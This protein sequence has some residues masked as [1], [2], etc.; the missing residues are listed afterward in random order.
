M[1]TLA[2]IWVTTPLIIAVRVVVPG[3]GGVAG[4]V[5]GGRGGAM[6]DRFTMPRRIGFPVSAATTRPRMTP[7]P[8]GGGRRTVS[9]GGCPCAE[10]R[11]GGGGCAGSPETPTPISC[12]NTRNTAV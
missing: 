8:V 4:D 12:E 11:G 10:G 3:G 1:E 9:R 5:L 7:V 6:G 2:V